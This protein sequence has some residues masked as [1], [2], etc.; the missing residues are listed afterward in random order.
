[1][2]EIKMPKGKL[3]CELLPLRDEKQPTCRGC[4]AEIRFALTPRG[5]HLPIS[6]DENGEWIAHFADCPNAD[7]L[8][9]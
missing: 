7:Q 4:K 1:M 5:K 6:K 8:R 9:K 2:I 3:N